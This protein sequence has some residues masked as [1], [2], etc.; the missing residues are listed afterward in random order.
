MNLLDLQTRLASIFHEGGHPLYSGAID[1]KAGPL[2][3]AAII[4]AME[5]GNDNPATPID[6]DHAASILNVGVEKIRT[7]AA[8]ET[9]GAAFSE[10]KPTILFEGHRFSSA[11]A[12]RFD[13][14]YPAISYPVWDRSK[15]PR[16]QT[17]RY[18]QLAEAV[19]LNV[20]A[21]FASASYGGFQILGENFARCGYRSSW[22]F[23]WAMSQSEA[24]QLEAFVRFVQ[25]DAVLLAALRAGDWAKVAA[26][27][28]GSAYALNQYDKKLA[29]RY[30]QETGAR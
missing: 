15:Y 13:A 5:I 26:R 28:N 27:Y 9:T 30:A 7:I 29:Q 4:D 24:D 25:S 20:D 16:T 1:G 2:T 23:A 3:K 10:G 19:C 21:G 18:Q 8:V 12:H 22:A 14:S 11:T 6:Y 17:G